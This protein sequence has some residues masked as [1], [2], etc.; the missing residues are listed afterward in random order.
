MANV[1]RQ[2]RSTGTTPQSFPNPAPALFVAFRS[3]ATARENMFHLLSSGLSLPEAGSAL[4]PTCSGHSTQDRL[5]SQ[6]AHSPG[7]RTPSLCRSYSAH[8]E[9]NRQW[10]LECDA[11][12]S[13]AWLNRGQGRA[14]FTCNINTIDCLVRNSP[15]RTNCWCPTSGGPHGNVRRQ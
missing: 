12:R 13:K 9:R 2:Q 10:R 1:A 3:C 11:P 5:H 14:R 7:S 8:V 6:V 4:K 15:K